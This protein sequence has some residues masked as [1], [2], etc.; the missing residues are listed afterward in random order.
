MRINKRKMIQNKI[1]KEMQNEK[2]AIIFPLKK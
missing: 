2:N 1:Q